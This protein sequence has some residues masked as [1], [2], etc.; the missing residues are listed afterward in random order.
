MLKYDTTGT[1]KS[2]TSFILRMAQMAETCTQIAMLT[3]V[4][5][6]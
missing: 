2:N 3:L 6:A 4:A 5:I 1:Q